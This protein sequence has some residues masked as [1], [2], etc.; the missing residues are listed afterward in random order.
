MN[1]QQ[2]IANADTINWDTF[3]F[4]SKLFSKD[5][6]EMFKHEIKIWKKNGK[7]HREDGPAVIYYD[8]SE[9]WYLNGKLHRE[10]GPAVIYSNGT[11]EWHLKGE[12]HREDGP[13][14][15]DSNGTEVWWVDGIE[16]GNG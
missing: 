3:E 1:E 11:K 16:I 15:I 12:R 5:F 6:G 4:D 8:G 14:V 10:D 13:A 7:F 9:F 2:I